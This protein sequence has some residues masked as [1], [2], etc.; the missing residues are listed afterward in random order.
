M[1]G[2]EVVQ[3]TLPGNLAVYAPYEAIG[4]GIGVVGPA[5][6]RDRF[7]MGVSALVEVFDDSVPIVLAYL[8]I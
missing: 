2:L 6:C 8:V 3:R 7:E 1:V 4:I 5:V